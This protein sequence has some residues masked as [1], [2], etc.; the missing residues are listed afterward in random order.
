MVSGSD[1]IIDSVKRAFDKHHEDGESPADIWIAFIEVP[2]TI[3]ETTTRIHSAKELAEKCELLEPN[4]FSHEVV[5]EL[6]IPEKYV[7]HEIS[8]QTLIRRGLREHNFLHLTTAEVRSSTAR[9]LQRSDPWEIGVTLGLFAKTFGARAPL[10]WVSHQLFYDCVWVKIVEDD[11]VRLKYAHGY[12]ETV[13]FQFFCDLD[14]GIDDSLCD[15]WLSDIDFFLDYEEFKEWQDMTEDSMTED[16]IEFWETWHD[17][18][19]Y[20]AIRELSAKEKSAYDEEK[21]K[22]LVKHEKK[23]AA[24]EAEALRIGL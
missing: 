7:V 13:D 9:E 12:T 23:R 4:K 5:F 16:L 18:D 15:W 8:L 6:A 14:D 20:G 1:R 19:C 10:T 24:I 3:K 21:I 17:T 22:L 2:S 11:V